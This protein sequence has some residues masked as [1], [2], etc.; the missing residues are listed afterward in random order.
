MT[1]VDGV[2]L[3][4]VAEE[5]VSCTFD[6]DARDG[7]GNTPPWMATFNSKGRG[8]MIALLLDTGAGPDTANSSGRNPGELGNLIGNDNVAQY[9]VGR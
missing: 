1:I 5:K 3:G 2:A 6:L 9:L 4:A 8:D 7:W